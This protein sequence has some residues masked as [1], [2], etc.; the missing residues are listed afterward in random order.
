MTR[1]LKKKK[2]LYFWGIKNNKTSTG[3]TEEDARIKRPEATQ[4]ADRI[5]KS[6]FA[7]ITE[8]NKET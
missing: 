5:N 8:K 7:L 4:Q 6:E 1:Y 2:G 3:L